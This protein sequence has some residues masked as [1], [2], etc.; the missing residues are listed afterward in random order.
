VAMLPTRAP[1]SG[2]LDGIWKSCSGSAHLIEGSLLDRESE[3]ILVAGTV[4]SKGAA[5]ECRGRFSPALG[6]IRWQNE[7]V[8]SAMPAFEVW[9]AVKI[10]LATL[11]TSG[12]KRDRLVSGST[13]PG[14][15]ASVPD[16]SRPRHVT[17]SDFSQAS[18]DGAVADEQPE[19]PARQAPALALPPLDSAEIQRTPRCEAGRPPVHPGSPSRRRHGAGGPRDAGARDSR[20]S[21]ASQQC[22]ELGPG[23]ATDNGL[24]ATPGPP[25][26]AQSL[27]SVGSAGHQD[28][29][30]LSAASG[31][32]SRA[33]QAG[34]QRCPQP[35][36]FKQPPPRTS[37][38]P[39]RGTFTDPEPDPAAANPEGPAQGSPMPPGGQEG[40]GSSLAPPNQ[41]R[42]GSESPA[43]LARAQP[44]A[45][46]A[47]PRSSRGGVRR[48]GS[49]GKP[50]GRTSSGSQPPPTFGEPHQDPP[51]E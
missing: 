23:D 36:R 29:G 22:V 30:A 15:L 6:T 17:G 35:N 46:T 49:R 48:A 14:S 3:I 47:T 12:A 2:R 19:A 7:E 1:D 5:G 4:L 39:E 44:P 41:H 50:W 13:A 18:C 43:K 25:G 24:A 51:H 26:L 27:P 16:F 34:A 8:W 11:A 31:S 38:G 21:E 40:T 10:G 32:R 33:L 42:E 37:H 28:D 20:S 9:Q 45:S